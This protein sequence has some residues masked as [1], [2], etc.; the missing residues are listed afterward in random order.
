MKRKRTGRPVPEER[1][2]SGPA[3]ARPFS[4]PFGLRLSIGVILIAL[5]IEAGFIVL[6]PGAVR[7]FIDRALIPG[8]RDALYLIASVLAVAALASVCAGLVRDFL[9]ARVESKVLGGIRGSLFERLHRLSISLGSQAPAAAF[10][11]DFS[12]DFAPIESAV[13]MAVPWG[14][15]PAMEALFGTGLMFWLDWRGGIAALLLWAWIILAP[16]VP[17]AALNR[18]SAAFREDETRLLDALKGALTA[19]TLVRAFS[20]ERMGIAR[21]GKRNDLLTR[22]AMRAGRLSAF[23]ERFTGAGIL[24]IQTFLLGLSAFLVFDRQMTVGTL[25][26]LQMLAVT[27]SNSLMFIVEFAPSIAA[28]QAAH[29]RMEEALMDALGD[30]HPVEDAPDARLLPPLQIEIVFSNVDF[31][32]AL[33]GVKARIPRG[34]SVAFVGPS[35]CGPSAAIGLLMRFHDPSSGFIAID[36][37]DLKALAQASLRSRLGFVPRENVLFNMSVRDNIRLGKPEASEEATIEVAR[38]VGL[39]DFI[40]TLPHGY[41]TPAGEDGVRLSAA[42][43]QRLAMARVMLRNPEIVLLDESTSALDLAEEADVGA[44]M[45]SLAQGRT[46]IAATHRPATAVD[47]DCIFFFDRGEIV[48][49]GSHSELLEANGGYAALWRKQSGF[50]FSADGKHV[51]VDASRLK[52]FPVLENLDEEILAELAPF[53]ATETFPPGREIVRQ[54]DPGDK[55]YVVVRGS[56]EVLRTEELSGDTKRVAILQDG[57][58]FGEVTLITSFPRTATVRTVTAC[59]CISLERDRFDR[60]LDDF[61]DLQRQ[62]AEVAIRRLRE[63]AGAA[64]AASPDGR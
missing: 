39:H 28:A 45:R 57:D 10:I 36:G 44:M 50:A 26:A 7:F 14:V 21:I 12:A 53:F 35:G 64:M 58:Y 4:L 42:Q 41:G 3:R 30:S 62:I 43:M 13:A 18:A 38:A 32:G 16:R 11:E 40:K 59:T 37:H 25:A 31:E 9:S 47:A 15:L 34:T 23:M 56:A 55:F 24:G 20:L 19:P 22:S 51:D 49:Q 48:E 29:R 1:P 6:V 60:T 27:L 52:A 63:S 2:A 33:S 5:L 54:N 17:A 8:N 61:P 46:L